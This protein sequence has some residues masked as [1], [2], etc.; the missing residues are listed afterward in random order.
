MAQFPIQFIQFPVRPFGLKSAVYHEM[1][2]GFADLF[3]YKI[4]LQG[5]AQRQVGSAVFADVAADAATDAC[6]DMVLVIALILAVDMAIIKEGERIDVP[7][8]HRHYIFR[9]EGKAA[10][11]A[12]EILLVATHAVHAAHCMLG[13]QHAMGAAPLGIGSQVP[14]LA[15]LIKLL[16]HGVERVEAKVLRSSVE[17]RRCAFAMA[18]YIAVLLVEH[19]AFAVAGHGNAQGHI[20]NRVVNHIAPKAVQPVRLGVLAVVIK[21]QLDA[22]ALIHQ[23]RLGK[24]NGIE[25]GMSLDHIRV[26][27]LCHLHGVGAIEQIQLGAARAK[28]ADII[29]TGGLRALAQ[30]SAEAKGIAV[31]RQALCVEEK[32][33]TILTAGIVAWTILKDSLGIALGLVGNNL[34]IRSARLRTCLHHNAQLGGVGGIKKQ[35]I[36]VQLL[37][38]GNLVLLRCSLFLMNASFATICSNR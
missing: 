37:D 6:Q 24:A 3:S 10:V 38:V 26:I 7:I 11:T 16:V 12:Q 29:S 14:H 13:A 32:T 18:A 9:A 31:A 5:N 1:Q 4:P 30:H 8:I 25:I 34:I 20:L 15:C 36:L 28:A 23:E 33:C 22:I 21:V 35:Q 2:P 17:Q 19:M 27:A